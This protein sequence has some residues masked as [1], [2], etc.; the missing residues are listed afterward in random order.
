M[1]HFAVL[2]IAPEKPENPEA[3][4]EE[5]LAPYSEHIQ[6]DPYEENCWC[7]GRVAKTYAAEKANADPTIDSIDVIRLNYR[8]D[9]DA[10][11]KV[12][13]GGED[14]SHGNR[15]K[16]Y[17]ARE[18]AVR[19]I[20][21]SWEER[22]KPLQDR[23]ALLEK[24]HPLKDKPDEGCEECNGSGKSTSTYN[25]KSKWDWY[26]IGGRWTGY[27]D[28]TYEPSKDPRNQTSCELCHGTG[29]RNDQL[30]R[31]AR[32]KDPTYTCNGCKDGV[33]TKW[34]TSWVEPPEGGNI[35]PISTILK[36]LDDGHNILTFAILR[37]TGEWLE[38]GEMG[39]WAC[40]SNEKKNWPAAA[41]SV[42]EE[43]QDSWGIVVDCHI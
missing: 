30:G 26:Q 6:V 7:V 18:E 13:M 40:V 24:M 39:W 38:K 3:Y 22:L 28:P 33:K 2:V 41:R 27:L 5:L 9:L 43:Y 4:I 35:A 31:D 37:P 14:Y 36:H 17:E 23:K 20:T 11:I 42:L 1:S 32:A 15:D 16:H 12:K 21:P 34:P 25:P 29:L 19:E 10:M 8:N